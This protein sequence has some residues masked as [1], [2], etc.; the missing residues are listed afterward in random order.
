MITIF[1]GSIFW[2][3]LVCAAIYIFIWHKHFDV[4]FT[5][6]FTLIPVAC[7]GYMLQGNAGNMKGAVIATQII[8]IGGCFL[9]LFILFFIFN[10]CRI[11]LSRWIRTALFAFS[12]VVYASTMTVGQMDFFYKSVYFDVADGNGVLVKEYGIMHTVFYVMVCLYFGAGIAA[13]IYSLVRKKQVPRTVIYLMLLPDVICILSYFA[14]R[15]IIKN[16]ELVPLGYLLAEVIVLLIA[17]R[18]N[19][20]DVADTVIDSM[21]QERGIGYISFDFKCRYLGCNEVALELM[22]ELADTAVDETFG[23]KPS[24]RKIRHFI[25]HF[26]KD[27]SHNLFVYTLHSEDQDPENDRIYNVSV[28]FLYDGF[29]RRGYLV[30]FTDDTANQKY[31]R[32]LDS[33]NDKLQNEVDEKTRHII[34]MHDNLIMSLAMM[35]ES[36]DNS[37][38]GHIMRTSEG[39][40]ILVDEIVK[41][42]SLNLSDD[43]CLDVIKAAPMHDLGK[44]A[45]DDAVL[46][47]PGR[48]TDEEYEKMKHHA[49]EGARVIH[50]ILLHTDDNSFKIVAENVA[51]YHHERWD[52]SGY[53]EK[54]K[55]EQIP[56]EARIMAVADVYDAL[57]SKRVYKEAFDFEKANAIIMEGMGTQFDPGL[58]TAYVNARPRLEEYYRS[59]N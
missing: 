22:P 55:G 37:T 2:I 36:R 47:K 56:I 25:D 53:P 9:Q 29:R 52:G 30:T 15:R 4:N 54:L 6:I 38:G 43:F 49:A 40:R 44:I 58:K 39:V 31:I 13:I 46:R 11:E 14:G 5:M 16:V 3:S 28:N 34:E 41:E 59:L 35:V 27:Q 26:K 21:V 32:L 50:E 48:F 51:H 7:L 24:Q 12:S 18:V 57:V 17:Y 42:G 20:Y 33:Y 45:V 23:Y 1:Y 19:L 8:Y 10:I